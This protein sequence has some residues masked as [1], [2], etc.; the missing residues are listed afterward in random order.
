[1]E[2]AA[3]FIKEK[4]R[5]RRGAPL[6]AEREPV[7]MSIDALEHSPAAESGAIFLAIIDPRL[8]ADTSGAEL[9]RIALQILVGRRQL[10]ELEGTI[11][12]PRLRAKPLLSAPSGSRGYSM[13]ERYGDAPKLRP[14]AERPWRGVLDFSYEP[15]PLFPQGVKLD[16]ADL[17][18]WE[19]HISILRRMPGEDDA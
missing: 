18:R 13:A 16:L 5:R 6:G 3:Y 7:E 19:P 15:K 2:A 12:P 9:R 10:G 11:S 1:L 14:E 8:V 4:S 17:P